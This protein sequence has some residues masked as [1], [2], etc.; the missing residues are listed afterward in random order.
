MTRH[1]IATLLA[2]GIAA[3]ALAQDRPK[4]GETITTES[5]LVYKFTQ[6]GKGPEPKTGDLMVIHGIGTLVDGKEFWNTRTEGAPYEYTLDVDSVIRGFSE[7]MH[8]VREGDR[9]II[10]MKPELGYG[11]RERTGIPAN[12]T[13]VFDYEILAVKPL[14]FAKLMRDGIAAGTVDDAIA[15]AKATPN[16]KDYYVSASSIQAAANAANRKEAGTNEKVLALGLTLLPD[17][18]QLHQTLGR[19]QATRGDKAAA[20][21]SY[22]T[23]LKLNPKK[24]ATEI[25][26]YEATTT[27]LAAIKI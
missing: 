3:P 9:I 14:T 20:I 16:L 5:G 27:A 19:L 18:Y 8:H 10:T 13:L 22:E 4:I 21:K 17:A 24:T 6:L 23:A 1:L 11:A 15:K 12:S 26:D 2:V 25:R 7:G